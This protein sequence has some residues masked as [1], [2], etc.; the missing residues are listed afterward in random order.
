M[1]MDFFIK[2]VAAL[3]STPANEQLEYFE[4]QVRELLIPTDAEDAK[5]VQKG[6]MLY[7]QGAVKQLQIFNNKITSMVQDVT[8]VYVKLDL[9]FASMSTCTCPAEGFCRHQVATFF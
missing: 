4:E 6:L 3:A 7:R 8:N 9:V 2:G 1:N 5:L